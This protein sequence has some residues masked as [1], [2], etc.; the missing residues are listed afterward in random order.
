MYEQLFHKAVHMV[1]LV[2]Q[3]LKSEHMDQATPCS[4][5]DVR[6]LL[7]H[8][9]NE[10]AW[11]PPLL[12]GKTVDDVGTSLDGD[13]LGTDANAAWRTHALAA[14]E[15]ASIVLPDAIVHLSYGDKSARAYLDE[16]GGDLIIH[17]WDLGMALQVPYVIDDPTA[18][19]VS[20]ATFSMMPEAKEGGMVSADVPIDENAS[21][22]EKLLAHFGRNIHWKHE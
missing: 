12:Q 22:S 13:L 10:L 9:V 7:Q 5:W 2:M 20:Q 4:E 11:V 21:P 8:M 17:G 3:D 1:N 16:V 14:V 6:A 19:Q 18:A 15:A